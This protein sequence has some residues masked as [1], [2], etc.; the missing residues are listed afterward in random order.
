[1]FFLLNYCFSLANYLFSFLLGSKLQVAVQ[2]NHQQA[3][4]T[5]LASSPFKWDL[6][7]RVRMTERGAGRPKKWDTC[8]VCTYVPHKS[9]PQHANQPTKAGVALTP[10]PH[11][12]P[13]PTICLEDQPYPSSLVLKGPVYRTE[14]KTEIGLNWTGKDWTSGLFMDQSFAVQLAVFLF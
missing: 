11:N 12:H 5:P 10:A 4:T 9:V 6:F 1:M 8:M 3:T 13:P 14:K 7:S 2:A